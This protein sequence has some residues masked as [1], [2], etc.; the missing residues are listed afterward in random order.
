MSSTPEFIKL[1]ATGQLP[2]IP[3]GCENR[4]ELLQLRAYLGELVRFTGAMAA[5]DLSATMQS[6]GPLAGRLKGL[7]ANLRHLTWQT[8]QVAAGDFN[9]QVACLGEFSGAFNRMVAALAQARQ[10]L[11]EKNRQLAAAY[12]DLKS[13]QARLLQQDKMASIGQLAAGVAHEIN[14]PMGFILSNLATLAKYGERLKEFIDCQSDAIEKLAAG[15]EGNAEKAAI[16]S[17]RRSLKIDRA[18]EDIGDL[19]S[20]SLEGG[21]RVKNIVM[22]LKNFSNVDQAT[23]QPANLNAA[24]EDTLAT[25]WNELKDKAT[26]NRDFGELPLLTCNVGQLNL[27]FMNILLNAVQALSGRGEINLRTSCDGE[28]IMIA[29]SDTGNGMPPE[30]A[31]RIFEPFFTTKEVG[32]GTGL[33]LSIDYDIVSKHRGTIEVA[34]QIGQ[35]TTISIRL[36]LAVPA[37]S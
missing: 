10:E 7:H 2:E 19:I 11:L 31:S 34:S 8:Q 21:T 37:T 32:Q 25:I 28:A 30:V 22:N 27:V 12:D 35:G 14:N 17:Q 9:Q 15:G 5:G 20:E 4:E 36:P 29:V 23:Q 1:F 16:Q 13:A 33:G 26:L 3:E 6:G 24:L 18:L